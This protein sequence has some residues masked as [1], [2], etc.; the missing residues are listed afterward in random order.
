M[1]QFKYIAVF[2][3]I[4][5]SIYSAGLSL[6]YVIGKNCKKIQVQQNCFEISVTDSQ[7]LYCISLVD[8]VKFIRQDESHYAFFY[9]NKV[10]EWTTPNKFKLIYQNLNE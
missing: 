8:D 2:F 7:A 1:N 9:K 4:V 3:A 10:Y 6:G 5:A